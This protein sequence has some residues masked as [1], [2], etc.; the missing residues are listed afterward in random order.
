MPEQNPASNASSATSDLAHVVTV[1]KP[2]LVLEVYQIRADQVLTTRVLA[3]IEK[4]WAVYLEAITA[5]E[6]PQH[7]G[8]QL[9]RQSWE[10]DLNLVDDAAIRAINK[11][12]RGKDSAT[13]VLSF[14]LYN[15]EASA[16][17]ASLPEIQLGSIFIS[18]EWAKHHASRNDAVPAYVLERFVHGLLHLMGQ[19][20]DTIED[21]RKVLAIQRDVL[22]KLGLEP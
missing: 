22:K 14:P 12:Y 4:L 2:P 6:V 19:N 11:Q 21:Y 10:I 9:H 7:L 8:L 17:A 1:E 13:D 16:V 18:L 5:M 15:E 3:H 20:H